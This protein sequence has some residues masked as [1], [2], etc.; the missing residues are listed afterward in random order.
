[1][2]PHLLADAGP[3]PPPRNCG[4]VSVTVST[5]KRDGITDTS[6]PLTRKPRRAV[7]AR[8]TRAPC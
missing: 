2:S 7:A 1:M 5:E 8:R 3:V 4:A 6:L